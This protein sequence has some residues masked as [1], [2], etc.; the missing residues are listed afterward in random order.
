MV[1]VCVCLQNAD[2]YSLYVAQNTSTQWKINCFLNWQNI[3]FHK[4]VVLLDFVKLL[5]DTIK[6]ECRIS[7]VHGIPISLCA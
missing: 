5:V 4:R 1:C 7:A 6:S 2:L 3:A